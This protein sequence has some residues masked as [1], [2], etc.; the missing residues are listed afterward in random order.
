VKFSHNALDERFDRAFAYDHAART[1]EAYS[2]SEA[3]DFT[4][5]TNSGTPTGPYRQSYQYSQFNQITQQT[6]RLWTDT[7]TTTSTFVNN[8]M[9]S[10]AY[11]AS[12]FVIGTDG[13]SYIRDA[14][15]RTVEAFD[16]V[17]HNWKKFDGDG[18]LNYNKL[19]TPGFRNTTRTTITYY[20]GSTVLGGLAVAE[21][22]SSG[23]KNKRYIYAGGRKLAEE[24]AGNVTWSH[25]EPVTGSRGDSNTG[26]QFIPK[27][28]FNAEGINVGFSAPV[29]T[30]F[31]TPEPIANWG[32]LGLGSGCS[33]VDPNCVTC[34][35]DGFEH[36]CGAVSNLIE[37]GAAQQCPNNDCGPRLVH[38]QNGN[39]GL[40]P[41][42]WDPN[43]GQLGWW[44]WDPKY[45]RDQPDNDPDSNIIR[46][47]NQG[48][49][50]WH[51]AP[52]SSVF[53]PFGIGFGFGP[54]NTKVGQAGGP[55]G[56]AAHTNTA[57]EN[58][59]NACTKQ[60][61]GVD[62]QSFTRS[63]HGQNGSFTG[64][65]ADAYGAGGSDTQI[66]VV[67]EVNSYTSN[68]LA[69]MA[70]LSPNSGVMGLTGTTPSGYTPYRNFTASG[71]TN[72]TAILATQVHELGN[73]LRRIT[74]VTMDPNSQPVPSG[75]H[76]PGTRLEKCVFG[77]EVDWNGHLHHY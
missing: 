11:D 75:D 25:E 21:L 56:P 22:N 9:Q 20:L 44:D 26:G 3:R 42:S 32:I 53:N 29:E 37:R 46:I 1:S 15:G 14:G 19:T 70:G 51:Y 40:Q 33:N 65:G 52:D 13:T 73:S 31:D 27:A 24:L 8:R 64:Y 74:R 76:D 39:P 49:Y 36:D 23:Q 60:L 48:A 4:S 72:S 47:N 18:R 38:D 43:T 57:F 35:L 59:L 69:A 12:G 55:A 17:S 66:T 16:G 2:G 45:H 5:G 77:G 41:L 6:N 7:E 50:L 28:E 30:G 10:W 61:F 68:Q 67:N 54:Q 34:F 58:K 63:R 71:L 62:L